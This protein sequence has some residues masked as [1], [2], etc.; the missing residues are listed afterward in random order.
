MASLQDLLQGRTKT[1]RRIGRGLGSGRGKTAGRG[2]KGQKARAGFSRKISATFEGGQT[3]VWRKSPKR[4]GFN[5]KVDRPIAVTTTL[6]NRFYKDGEEVSPDTLIAKKI[7]RAKSVKH[8]VKII[9]RSE[10]TVKVKFAQVA[11]S[12]SLTEV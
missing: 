11:L 3:P 1:R 12:K 9:K 6:I 5:H 8:G 2:T 7:V 4:R 10:L